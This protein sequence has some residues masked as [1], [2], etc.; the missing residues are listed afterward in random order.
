MCITLSRINDRKTIVSIEALICMNF[1]CKKIGVNKYLL[2]SFNQKYC[3]LIYE[4]GFS[5]LPIDK[6]PSPSSSQK[7]ASIFARE[8]TDE[9][10]GV[11]SGA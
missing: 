5:H 1:H 7:G 6:S 8:A 4:M 2:F 9:T 10:E 3:I 11:S